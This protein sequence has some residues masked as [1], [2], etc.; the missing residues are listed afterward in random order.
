[1]TTRVETAPAGMGTIFP[2]EARKDAE[3]VEQM[4]LRAF[5]LGIP[6]LRAPTRGRKQIAFAR[7]VAL[8]AMHVH[9]GHSLSSTARQF[10]RDRTTVAHACRLVEDLRDG[11]AVG[12]IIGNIE[13]GVAQWFALAETTG[14][15]SAEE[16]RR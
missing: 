8:Y 13:A 3:L 5:G 11:P 1:M 15:A 6:H 4:V 16:V 10:G 14:D 7:Q 2:R 12:E 9:F